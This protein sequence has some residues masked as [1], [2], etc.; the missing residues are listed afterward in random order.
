MDS[1][2][3]S[4]LE[5][6][7]LGHLGLQIAA[8]IL[9]IVVGYVRPDDQ[10][11]VR[12]GSYFAGLCFVAVAAMLIAAAQGLLFMGATFQQRT[13]VNYLMAIPVSFVVGVFAMRLHVARANDIWGRR[14]FAL[15][16][17]VPV[18][19]LVMLFFRSARDPQD[20]TGEVLSDYVGGRGVWMGLA[21]CFGV[22]LVS[23]TV[24]VMTPMP[25]IEEQIQ[26][27][28]AIFPAPLEISPGVT[29]LP[30]DAEGKVLTM[31]LQDVS[32]RRA[33]APTRCRPWRSPT[34]R[35]P[36]SPPS[37]RRAPCFGCG[38][39]TGPAPR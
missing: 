24:Q 2:A 17:L 9:G 35:T 19:G 39:P 29:I 26:V 36:S 3:T 8:T 23:G 13:A 18:A 27:A 1:L 34:A 28:A 10:I 33:R 20:R 21:A 5:F 16:A 22:G 32:A 31:T 25:T 30:L 38:S 37:S 6:G 4:I 14:P 11:F 12:R 15:L 7:I